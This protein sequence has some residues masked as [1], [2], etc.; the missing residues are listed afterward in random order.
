MLHKAAHNFYVAERG[1]LTIFFINS[2]YIATLSYKK[3]RGV[4]HANHHT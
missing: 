2:D 3:L 4:T 1:N